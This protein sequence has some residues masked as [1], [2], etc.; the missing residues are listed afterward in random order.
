MPKKEDKHWKEAVLTIKFLLVL[1]NLL[2]WHR[3]RRQA[4]YHNGHKI[5]FCLWRKWIRTVEF[6]V[7]AIKKT[8]VKTLQIGL[9]LVFLN[10]SIKHVKEKENIS[11]S[12]Q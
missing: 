7:L 12:L 8:S 3:F 6:E 11:T 5:T 2:L 9:Y 4:T 10:V 1:V